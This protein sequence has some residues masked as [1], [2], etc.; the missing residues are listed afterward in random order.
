SSSTVSRHL[1]ALRTFWAFLYRQDMASS[2]MTLAEMDI[3][4][5]EQSNKTK[6]LRPDDYEKF[7]EDLHHVLN[8]IY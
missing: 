1:A 4:H 6:P 2:P 7:T 8:K 5:E 3:V